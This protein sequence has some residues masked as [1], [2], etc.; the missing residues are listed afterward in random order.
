MPWDGCELHVAD[1]APNGDL[2]D[3]EHVAGSDGAESIW[4]PEWSPTGDLV[5]AS[6]RSGWW[7]LERIR[8]DER[9][10]LHTAHAEFGYPAWI[11]GASSYA[12]L[13]DGRIVCAYD[14]D[15]FTHF[16]VLDSETGLLSELD[17]GLDSLS[18]SPYVR[19]EGGHALLVAGTTDDTQRDRPRRRGLRKLDDL[20][21]EH[22]RR[23]CRGVP[24]P[25]PRRSS[26][27]RRA[28]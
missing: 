18:G 5:F 23:P 10:A 20:A 28:G 26:S 11:F 12:F 9:T 16:G 7:N 17:L 21:D 15:G 25:L 8:G 1:L 24:S 2:S 14:S 27:R 13:D 22:R 4:Q 3:V 6:D 19:A